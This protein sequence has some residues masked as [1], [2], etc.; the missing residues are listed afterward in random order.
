MGGRRW[1]EKEIQ[2]INDKYPYYKNKYGKGAE[3]EI[4][5]RLK[6]PTNSVRI[7]VDQLGLRVDKLNIKHI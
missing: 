1:T 6:R 2:F 4:G 3:R 7:K 5:L